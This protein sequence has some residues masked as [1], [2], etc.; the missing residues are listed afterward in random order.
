MDNVD[1]KVR[2]MNMRE[3]I[4]RVPVDEDGEAP[5][6]IEMA[7][8]SYCDGTYRISRNHSPI[9]VFE[10][11]LSGQG[12]VITDQTEFTA[13]EG[14]IYILH[15]GSNHTYFSDRKNPWTK[16]W[17]NAGGPLL[18]HLMEVYKLGGVFHL[19]GV[20]LRELFYDILS[21]VQATNESTGEIIRK[22]SLLLHE[23]LLRIHAETKQKE[24]TYSKEALKLKSYLD[25]HMEDRIRLTDLGSLIYRSPAQVIRI[26]KKEFNTTPYEYLLEKRIE[27][28]KLMLLNTN[29]MVKEIAL[30]LRFSEEH[31][32]SNYFKTR[33]GAS[34]LEYRYR[35]M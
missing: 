34:P 17:F 13:E 7:G 1:E 15:A 28:A 11:I 27:T 35:Q 18:G 5:F 14:D 25:R 23:I 16:V 22:V 24:H 26:F 31:Y 19:K 20:D 6:Y 8:V 32:F 2:N 33:T 29:I 10:Y 12:T 21:A 30:R 9:Y 3:D 4:V